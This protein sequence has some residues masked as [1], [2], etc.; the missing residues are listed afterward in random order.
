MQVHQGGDDLWPEA[1]IA[2]CA[3]YMCRDVYLIVWQ[4][5]KELGIFKLHSFK[6]LFWTKNVLIHDYFK[7][8]KPELVHWDEPERWIVMLFL[9]WE[10][11]FLT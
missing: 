10:T 2:P 1:E 6:S 5:K 3:C 4:P 9:V 11:G 7:N 8:V